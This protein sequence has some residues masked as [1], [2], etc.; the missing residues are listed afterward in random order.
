MAK[1][2]TINRQFASGGREIGKRLADLMG[3]AYYDKELIDSVAA[4]TG[5]HPEYI[6]KYSESALSRSYPYTFGRT[7]V[8]YNNLPTNIIQTSQAKII[9][10]LADK[11]DC[12]IIGRA[13]NYLL[14]DANP[15][16]IYIYAADMDF[17]IERCYQKN[18]LDKNKSA[19][20]M[21]KE[22]LAIDKQRAKY[23]EYLANQ[24]WQDMNSYHLCLDSS[25]IG[26]KKTVNI[27]FEAVNNYY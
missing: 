24:K 3:S 1:I 20:E 26:L 14:R 27:I 9:C 13:A 18:P 19:K 10:D 6:E 7:F 17:R 23:Y 5:L 22:I 8:A 11:G 12:V 4:D 15:L 25:R 2:V 16:S 21:Q